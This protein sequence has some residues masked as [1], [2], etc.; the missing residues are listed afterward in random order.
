MVA[1]L[2][3]LWGF[4][5]KIPQMIKFV[6]Q[7]TTPQQPPAAPCSMLLLSDLR[8]PVFRPPPPFDAHCLARVWHRR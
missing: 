7:A 6:Y 3:A 1:L 4:L 2:I 8:C 5:H